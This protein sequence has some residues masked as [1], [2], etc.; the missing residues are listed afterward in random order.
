MNTPTLTK[1]KIERKALSKTLAIFPIVEN[2][3]AL[4]QK[5]WFEDN[6]YS[7]VM[8]LCGSIITLAQK[9]KVDSEMVM[10]IMHMETTHGYYDGYFP[11]N[12]L[13]KTIRP[14][15]IHY[16]YWEKM[17]VTR[18]KLGM[19]LYNVEFGVI[20]LSRI[21]A[22]INEPTI[23]KIASIYNALRAEKVTEYGERVNHFYITKPWRSQGCRP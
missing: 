8:K 9:H 3:N 1:P 4:N 23:T 7:Q 19:P 21:Q 11:L 17:G 16:E 20:L 22:R 12:H 13:N 10:A 14:M 15:N 18:E 6:E 5:P 2:P